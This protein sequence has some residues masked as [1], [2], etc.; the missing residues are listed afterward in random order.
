[1]I[2]SCSWDDKE[3]E[4]VVLE[5]VDGNC[6]PRFLVI[7]IAG[8]FSSMMFST[9]AYRPAGCCRELSA[10]E[11]VNLALFAC[12]CRNDFLLSL[13]TTTEGKSGYIMMVSW[14]VE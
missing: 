7:N 11:C 1:M 4:V 9:K 14:L 5:N 10:D 3:Q 13:T 6:G 8:A 2:C 12:S